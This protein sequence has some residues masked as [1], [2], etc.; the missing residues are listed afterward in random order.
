MNHIGN[1]SRINIWIRCSRCGEINSMKKMIGLI[2]VLWITMIWGAES[3]LRGVWF[4]WAGADVP[5]KIAIA[6]AMDSL[7]HNGIN[8][9]FV[10]VW[11]YGYPYYPSE[12]FHRVTGKWTD[13]R[14]VKTRDVLEDMLAEAHRNQ[15]EVVAWFEWGFAVSI[16]NNDDIFRARPNWFAKDHTGN[17]DF[18]SSEGIAY[19]WLSHCHPQAQ[20]F[21][22]D[23]CKEV[24]TKYDID[25]IELDRIR[26]PQMDC[27][28]DSATIALYQGEHQGAVPPQ[29]SSDAGWKAWR[30]E[31]MTLFME[32]VYDTLKALNPNVH[33]S[34]APIQYRYGFDNFCQDWRPWINNHYLDF[35][36]PQIYWLTNQQY[37]T[38]LN[39]QL[40]HIQDITLCYPGITTTANGA[41]V[42]TSELVSMIRST[43]NRGLKGH[44]IW[45]HATLLDDLPTLKK[46]VY[47]DWVTIPGR[48]ADWRSAPLIINE[49]DT[50]KV[51]TS[52]H[53]KVYNGIPGY[54][55]GCYYTDV[56]DSA[57]VEYRFTIP[58]SGWYEIYP[59]LITHYKAL[60]HARYYVTHAKGIDTLQV[61]QTNGDRQRWFRL[62]D[63]Y[64]NSGDQAILRITSQDLNQQ[65]LF[66]DAVMLLNTNR[67][68]DTTQVSVKEAGYHS[69]STDCIIFDS[70]WPNP[71]SSLFH[72]RFFL[73]TAQLLSIQLYDLSGRRVMEMNKAYYTKGQHESSLTIADLPN[74][75]YFCRIMGSDGQAVRRVVIL[76]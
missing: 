5:S 23:L 37:L 61:D 13:E 22:L 70:I 20:Q 3:E 49:Y 26:Y 33:I 73:R 41:S 53:W 29:N 64:F 6:N 63:Y 51:T 72:F 24:I 11:R 19:K 34:N 43:R 31:K 30:G 59:F 68:R 69:Q 35:I 60:N 25:G 9:V 32:M 54:Q 57:W 42:A 65:Y 74:G 39:G 56:Q 2:L 15:M 50:L 48:A 44:V 17:T 55:G 4:A 27:G 8:T 14:N 66:T 58:N 47:Q 21:L 67:V 71:A 7:A 52:N 38:E 46:E 28:Y 36:S 76:R 16:G 62:G 10:D 45:Y 75:I 12:V 18:T 1:T 40:A